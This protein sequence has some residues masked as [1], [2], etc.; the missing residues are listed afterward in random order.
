MV[1]DSAIRPLHIPPFSRDFSPKS[2]E[3]KGKQRNRIRQAT[4]CSNS[5]TDESTGIVSSLLAVTFPSI[6]YHPAVRP[7]SNELKRTTR[8]RLQ[9]PVS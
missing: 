4:N 2:Q 9:L 5:K 6:R 3:T 1:Y 8:L 7:H